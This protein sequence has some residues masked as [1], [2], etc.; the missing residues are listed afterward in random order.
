MSEAD[1][2]LKKI[3]EYDVRAVTLRPETNGWALLSRTSRPLLDALEATG[4]LVIIEFLM[5]INAK[6]ME[7]LLDRHPGLFVLAR[8]VWWINQRVMLPLLC[9]YRNLHVAFDTFQIHYGIEWLVGQGCENQFIFASNAPR[10]S[11]GAH[12][13]YVDYADVSPVIKE[14]I[15]AGNLVRLLGGQK[16][17]RSIINGDED[18]IMAAARH[19]Q[20]LSP[21][22]LDFHAHILDEGLHGAGLN[23]VILNGGP[24]GV[25]RMAR[26]LGV[27]GIGL[28][29]WNRPVGVHAD[30]GNR[31][32][33][34]A[35]NVLPDSCWGLGTFDPVRDTDKMTRAKMQKLF[36][37]DRFLGL[38]PYP[39]YGPHY[40]D[41]AHE[42][43]WQFGQENGLY[44]LL[45]PNRTDLSEIEMLC[46]RYPN[47]IFV[48]AHCGGSYKV[49]ETAINLA[50]RYTNFYAELTLTTVPLGVIEYLVSGC[51][52]DRVLYGSD[53][54]MRDPR[55]QLGWGVYSRLGVQ[56][57][58]KVLGLNANALLRH[59]RG[60]RLQ[61]NRS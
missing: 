40:D 13:C 50:C 17:P 20:P 3:A 23:H 56:Q 48:A 14:K 7:E 15:S 39:E 55:P 58:E 49:A 30:D 1:V 29:S 43:W 22:V 44:A 45:H 57:K 51:G 5:D 46:S 16:P 12:R 11:I 52:A 33:Q 35:L 31:C 36:A 53:L 47:M 61:R 2:L 19:G 32:T 34:A 24:E 59:V 21:L 25:Q 37:D 8:N 9:H 18:P 54:P 38:K 60:G 27:D 42:V 4:T 10:M 28:M 41:P 26:R 6:G